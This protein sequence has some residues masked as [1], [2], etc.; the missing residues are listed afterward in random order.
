MKS[1]KENITPHLTQIYFYLLAIL[2]LRL[3]LVFL[4][5]M[6]TGGDMGA[7]IVP[8]KYFIENFA[9]DF[10]LNGWSNDWFA[11]YPLYFFYFPLPAIITFILN[12]FSHCYHH[13]LQV[14]YYDNH[15]ENLKFYF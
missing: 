2:I 6:P 4:N 14:L 12:L 1:L 5:T 11:G 13:A 15:D 3:D 10:Q 8:I 9:T 7:H